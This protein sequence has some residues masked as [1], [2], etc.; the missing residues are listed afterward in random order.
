MFTFSADLSCDTDDSTTLPSASGPG[1]SAW[2]SSSWPSSQRESTFV[3]G[4]HVL[5]SDTN[6][7]HRCQTTITWSSIKHVINSLT[8][9]IN[10]QR[11]SARE[12]EG[13]GVPSQIEPLLVA[14]HCQQQKGALAQKKQPIRSEYAC[15]IFKQSWKMS[16]F[17]KISSEALSQNFHTM[18]VRCIYTHLSKWESDPAKG[19]DLVVPLEAFPPHF[20]QLSDVCNTR[21]PSL[22]FICETCNTCSQ[23]R[24]VFVLVEKVKCVFGEDHLAFS[25]FLV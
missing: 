5:A 18:Y 20:W 8:L 13:P 25:F 24:F 11:I 2:F 21:S 19:Q 10:T 12:R 3:W 4:A 17:E 14:R 6:S 22:W 15:Q 1:S 7:T 9:D 23:L 16:S